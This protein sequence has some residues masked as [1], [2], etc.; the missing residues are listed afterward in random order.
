MYLLTAV[1][2]LSCRREEWGEEWGWR[3]EKELERKVNCDR[4]TRQRNPHANTTQVEAEADRYT[5]T[6]IGGDI[7]T[8]TY[9][10]I[11]RDIHMHTYAD[12]DTHTY[13]DTTWQAKLSPTPSQSTRNAILE[14]GAFN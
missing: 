9:T 1:V 4:Q 2:F 13:A 11:N 10:G 8:H 7:Y 5:G 14:G 3:K 12:I 6:G